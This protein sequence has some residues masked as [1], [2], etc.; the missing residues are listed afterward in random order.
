[1]ASDVLKRLAAK[2]VFKLPSKDGDLT[3]HAETMLRDLAKKRPQEVLDGF[4]SDMMVGMLPPITKS[5][6]ELG[7]PGAITVR[8]AIDWRINAEVS[9]APPYQA[10]ISS[11]LVRFIGSMVSTLQSGLG[12]NLVDDEGR[13]ESQLEARPVRIVARD[14][15]RLLDGF[16]AEQHVENL[17]AEAE[18]PRYMIHFRLL[19]CALSWALG[20]E[21]GHI[22]VTESKRRRID[23]PFQPLANGLLEGHF[24]QLLK[25]NR[26]RDALGPLD[27][28]S[29]LRL[30]DSWLTE[31]N[32]D[33]IGASLA[34]GYQKEGGPSKG[35][36]GVV[37][38]TMFAIH[39][40]LMSQYLLATYMNLLNDRQ[41]LAS[42]THPPID[43]RMH[44]VLM[45][46]YKD[47]MREATE[48]PVAYVQ[49]VFTEVLR[50]AGATV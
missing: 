40:V 22:V 24:E 28:Q 44:C 33:I 23:A 46:M 19:H 9:K 50:Q 43:F 8:Q 25:D 13:Q 37:S 30:F 18:G 39:L 27:E 47:R 35:I 3:A 11:S 4:V 34:C 36:P 1:M 31:I 10:V 32:A 21:L 48:H 20:H 14:V 26:F 12:I 2:G 16:I 7:N 5:L 15:K 6:P 49:Q 45:W 17:D 29:R 38:F 41:A 42:P